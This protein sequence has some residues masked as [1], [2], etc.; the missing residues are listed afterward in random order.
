MSLILCELVKKTVFYLGIVLCLSCGL[1]QMVFAHGQTSMPQRALDTEPAVEQAVENVLRLNEVEWK[2]TEHHKANATSVCTWKRGRGEI[3]FTVSYLVSHEDA[4]REIKLTLGG[5]ALNG[6]RFQ[7]VNGLGD[8]AYVV[9]EEDII[10]RTKNVAVQLRGYK[11][12]TSVLKRFAERIAKAV[13]A[14]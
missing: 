12:K 1:P 3:S 11:V 14:A 7:Q 10:F 9:T 5:I 6:P 8:E 4:R 13:S 2:L